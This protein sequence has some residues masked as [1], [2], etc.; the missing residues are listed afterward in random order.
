M[1]ALIA[2]GMC[3]VIMTGR[4]RPLGRL[5]RGDVRASS[6]P[7]FSPMASWPARGRPT[8][9]ACGR[10]TQRH[11]ITRLNSSLSSRRWPGML[12]RAA[13]ACSSPATSRSGCPMKRL[14]RHRASGRHPRGFQCRPGKP[15]GCC[16]C[17]MSVKA[18]LIGHPERLVAGDEQAGAARPPACWPA[19]R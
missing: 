19:S 3:F 11:P 10:R 14:H 4:H 17:P 2:L 18:A 12:A 16:R 1:F 7:I 13:P 6:P 9:A 8:A 5:D 15:R